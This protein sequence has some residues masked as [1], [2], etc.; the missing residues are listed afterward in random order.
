[1]PLET[2]PQKHRGH[3]E[4]RHILVICILDAII[5]RPRSIIQAISMIHPARELPGIHPRRIRDIER[6]LREHAL[7]DHPQQTRRTPKKKQQ[8]HEQHMPPPPHLQKLAKHQHRQTE[9]QIRPSEQHHMTARPAKPQKI[10]NPRR[11][12][13]ERMIIHKCIACAL[14]LIN[15]RPRIRD[16]IMIHRIA[17]GNIHTNRPDEITVRC[18]QE[19]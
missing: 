3:Q 1:M 17:V 13:P 5:R 12:Q 18:T 16:Q 7:H 15:E 11:H 10:R 6:R 4:H 14:I 8:A 19:K 2:K 9:S